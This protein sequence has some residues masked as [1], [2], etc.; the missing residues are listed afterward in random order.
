MY[1]LTSNAKGTIQMSGIVDS[2][3]A[4]AVRDFFQEVNESCTIDCSG[5]DFISSAGLGILIATYKRVSAKGGTIRLVNVQDNV[6]KIF[7]LARFDR[8]F[9]IE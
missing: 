2:S 3:V 4:D 5:L 6:R 1:S 8:L 7:L 9:T